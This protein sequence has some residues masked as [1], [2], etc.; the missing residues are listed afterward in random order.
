VAYNKPIQLY[1]ISSHI[2]QKC[3]QQTHHTKT[4]YRQYQEHNMNK[5]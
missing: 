5:F 2:K 1:H 3:T 4:T